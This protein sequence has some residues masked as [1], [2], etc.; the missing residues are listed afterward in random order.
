MYCWGISSVLGQGDLSW[1]MMYCGPGYAA[2]QLKNY[3]LPAVHAIIPSSRY[4]AQ[5][6]KFIPD[7]YDPDKWLSAAAA[8]T[9]G[10]WP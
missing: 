2:R 9:A 4:W 10:C 7:R 8:L 6:E 3:G 5:A 1:S